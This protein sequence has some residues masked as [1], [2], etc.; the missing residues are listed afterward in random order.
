MW[1]KNVDWGVIFSVHKIWPLPGPKRINKYVLLWKYSTLDKGGRRTSWNE[2]EETVCIEPH[3]LSF[4]PDRFKNWDMCEK[5]V[6]R[7]P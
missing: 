3:S 2:R 5:V 4:V 6:R 1:L 7:N